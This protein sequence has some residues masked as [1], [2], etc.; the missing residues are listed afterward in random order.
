MIPNEQWCDA[1]EIRL[2][3]DFADSR[4]LPRHKN[5]CGNFYFSKVRGVTYDCA[6]DILAS[7]SR[8]GVVNLIGGDGH[9][10]RPSASLKTIVV[11]ALHN[12]TSPLT[13]SRGLRTSPQAARSDFPSRPR[14]TPRL[15]NW[16]DVTLSLRDAP[17]WSTPPAK[18]KSEI[19]ANRHDL[20]STA[21]AAKGC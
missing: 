10:H 15:T 5:F 17:L 12:K 1:Q 6:V 4:H 16:S 2:G 7:S 3:K 21:D 13:Q 11:P 8:F 20:E 14:E 19:A 9:F 18:V